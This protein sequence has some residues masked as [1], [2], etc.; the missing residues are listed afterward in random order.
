MLLFYII[1]ASH[2]DKHP[3]FHNSNLLILDTTK[4]MNENQSHFSLM[5]RGDI[6][7]SD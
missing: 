3:T 1:F 4:I 6:M 5:R 7:V 2:L